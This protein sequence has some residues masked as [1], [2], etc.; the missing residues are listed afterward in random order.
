[1]IINFVGGNNSL[2]FIL[3]AMNENRG[4]IIYASESVLNVACKQIRRYFIYNVG[5]RLEVKFEGRK[6][7]VDM[8]I[9]VHS[10]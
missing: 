7:L 5:R 8:A 1:M 6:S 4:R 3:P 9:I 2:K 10:E